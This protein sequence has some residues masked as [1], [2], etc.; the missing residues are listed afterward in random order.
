[1]YKTTFY[2]LRSVVGP[3]IPINTIHHFPTFPR[4]APPFTI[5][6]RTHQNLSTTVDDAV[7]SHFLP[8]I[9][10][11]GITHHPLPGMATMPVGDSRLLPLGLPEGPV[12]ATLAW[13]RSFKNPPDNPFPDTDPVGSI[14]GFSMEQFT[15]LELHS[16]VQGQP[17]RINHL[18]SGRDTTHSFQIVLA[19]EVLV[20]GICFS[21][22]PYIS[23]R[24][25]NT[26]ECMTVGN[27]GLPREI[28]LT[29]LLPLATNSIDSLAGFQRNQFID[30]E[31]AYTRQ[32]IISHSGL[33]Y[34]RIDP[35]KTNCFLLTFTDLP[36]I[37]KVVDLDSY[38]A[39]NALRITGF[40][41]FALPYLYFFEYK[42]T[43]KRHARLH[44]GL[45][46]VKPPSS[47]PLKEDGT[48]DVLRRAFPEYEY[49]LVEPNEDSDEG[50]YILYTAHS[51]LGQRRLFEGSVFN[52]NY[53]DAVTPLI[54]Q[55]YKGLP[56][57]FV[58]DLLQTDETVTL[59]L[60]QGEEFDR[61]IA[62]LKALLLL[63]PPDSTTEQLA[64]RLANFLGVGSS[65]GLLAADER[66]LM[67][68]ALAATFRLPPEINFCEKVGIRI[69]E[70]DPPEG[71]S[72]ASVDLTKK[73]AT[74]LADVVI[75]DS[76]DVIV[77][78]L[79]KGIPFR[80]ISSSRYFAVA[81]TNLGVAGQIALHSLQLTR[82]AHVS[83]QPRPAKT[84]SVKT[85]HY[86]ILGAELADDFSK[87]G[88]EGFNFSIDRLAAGQTKNVL[89]SA[90]SLLDLLHTGGARIHSN[91][92]RRAIE[93][94]MA[95]N[96]REPE[97]GQGRYK[98]QKFGLERFVD[99]N[100][101]NRTSMG[102]RRSE[103]GEGVTWASP[104]NRPQDFPSSIGESAFE[105]YGTNENRV[106]SSLLFPDISNVDWATI[107]A[108]GNMLKVI[109]DPTQG[110]QTIIDQ[111]NSGG[112]DNL[113]SFIEALIPDGLLIK[114][115]RASAAANSNKDQLVKNFEKI[116]KG[117][118]T[119]ANNL[120]VT[121]I[122]SSSQSPVGLSAIAGNAL[123]DVVTALDNLSS[124]AADMQAFLTN[125]DVAAI[126]D[127][128]VD[129]GGLLDLLVLVGTLSATSLGGQPSSL[130]MVPLLNGLTLGLTSGV[131]V[132][133]SSGP[134]L[135]F[136]SYQMTASSG[137]TG[138]INKSANKTGYSY[139]QSLNVGYD[140]SVLGESE[141]KRI[142]T[143][144]ELL[145]R[146][147][148]RV[149]GAE[150]MWQGRLQDIITGSIPLNFSLPATATKMNFRTADD[151]LRVRFNSG[152]SPSVEV[153]VWFELTEETITDDH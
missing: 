99:P 71:L 29:P 50:A 70:I 16:Q 97:L 26:P 80:R 91:V 11:N 53:P 15:D 12:A 147:N 44:S 123:G 134:N 110:I 52:L 4:P 133:I 143:R 64:E 151:A 152:F 21:G 57:C 6:V 7:Y 150:V 49:V 42:E 67:E 41:G 76:T 142:V 68:D 114:S 1:M 106:H 104:N 109:T 78:L 103:T 18:Y 38:A 51:S 101:D 145:E 37:P 32:E 88:N 87:L 10:L 83:I 65:D 17:E 28:G 115:Y 54:S 48:E 33:N 94:E 125:G 14:F 43:T 2:P 22:Y 24:L 63:L 108:L 137:S 126:G 75:D 82:S 35:I 129:L 89:Y 62:G 107:S 31:F 13:G 90:M 140:N 60:Q 135:I 144:R 100:Q 45:L 146:D 3:S 148:E 69:Y 27:F 8:D 122:V 39:N 98:I 149:R 73:Y 25:E 72:P 139:N 141:T 93:F 130:A 136:P 138:S 55:K 96:Y 19:K 85:M 131:G 105:S 112:I 84:Q 59:Y 128:L 47:L 79:L 132:N 77:N 23:S 121:G 120:R 153:D 40:K 34:L 30:S 113:R 46:G 56:E 102:W 127:L 111:F 118:S 119:S 9:L 124:I 95:E 81:L 58:S 74:L 66:A 20:G 92:R 116:W 61:C 117:I 5:E 86:R 36:F